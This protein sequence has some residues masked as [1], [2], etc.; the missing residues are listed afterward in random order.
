MNPI[1]SLAVYIVELII[2]SIF[3]SEIFEYRLSL[4]KRL[5]IGGILA[6]VGSAINIIFLNNGTIVSVNSSSV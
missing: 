3:L 4:G 6:S 2:S 1:F 5:L